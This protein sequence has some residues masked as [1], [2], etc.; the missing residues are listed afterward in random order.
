MRVAHCINCSEY[1]YIESEGMCRSCS[2]KGNLNIGQDENNA[3]NYINPDSLHYG[4][5]IIGDYNT[6]K[7]TMAVHIIK[8]LQD[9][10]Y[11][12]FYF[13][14]KNEI[15]NL[16][17]NKFNVVDFSDGFNIMKIAR[18]VGDKNYAE[19]VKN[20]SQIVKNLIYRNTNDIIS[21]DN[22]KILDAVIKSI[23]YLNKEYNIQKV[24][25]CLV[26]LTQRKK[27]FKNSHYQLISTKHN[28]SK[29]KEKGLGSD[30]AII[31]SLYD[32]IYNKNLMDKISKIGSSINITNI[33][34]NKE[35]V[36]F[37]QNK[38]LQ[39]SSQ[40]IINTSVSEK[41]YNEIKL[42]NN[43]SPDEGKYIF[44]YDDIQKIADIRE[45]M[46][47]VGYKNNIGV[48][49]IISGLYGKNKRQIKYADNII[50][51]R[52]TK[53][54]MAAKIHK[55]LG[56]NKFEIVNMED[57]RYISNIQDTKYRGE[58]KTEPF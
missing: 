5:N 54:S 55:I 4:L 45:K 22:K 33:V 35:T 38:L 57:Y 3:Y 56:V 24:Y 2:S 49:N 25:E 7:S 44:C 51:F 39:S 41:I 23:L 43:S 27:L 8:Q 20:T 50:S 30:D 48:I 14:D 58:I 19:E 21:F 17:L 18:D 46:L 28:L 9:M 29:V 11:G 16:H 40:R 52:I 42:Q 15:T 26:D 53:T 6:G 13:D 31:S 37:S 12:V 47:N 34:N 10:E 1:K 32:L 36:I